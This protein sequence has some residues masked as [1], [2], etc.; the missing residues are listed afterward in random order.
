MTKVNV[1]LVIIAVT[2]GA[3]A[4]G[5]LPGTQ[6][7]ATDANRE[8]FAIVQKAAA[9][10]AERDGAALL[11]L[12]SPRYFEDNGTPQ[13]EDDYGYAEL[14]DKILPESLQ[15]AKEIFVDVEVQDIAVEGDRAHADLRYSSRTQLQLP[16][17]SI[18]DTH[19]EFNRIELA[20]EEGT[21]KI[22]SGL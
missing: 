6:I 13:R 19:R 21:W 16:A 18:W 11:A 5:R 14:K 2:L 10:F 7:P 20:R 17:G 9:A 4:H 15:A 12:V 8:I 1:L 22:T 3:C